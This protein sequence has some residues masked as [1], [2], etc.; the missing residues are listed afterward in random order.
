MELTVAH[1]K[2]RM[3]VAVAADATVGDL[4]QD[5]WKLRS[6]PVERQRVTFK[7]KNLAAAPEEA[8]SSKGV[9]TG[10]KLL[11]TGE[12][13]ERGDAKVAALRQRLSALTLEHPAAAVEEC[14]RIL[15]A[16]DAISLA[17]GDDEVRALRRELI[18]AAQELQSAAE[19]AA[20]GAG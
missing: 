4:M 9:G 2:D 11:L 15:E 19:K 7:G 18:K 5:L 3:Q 17:P 13:V 6:V 16:A 10:A 20:D 1:G 14:Q 12:A 8:L